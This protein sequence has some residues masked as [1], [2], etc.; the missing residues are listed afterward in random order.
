MVSIQSWLLG[1]LSGF[2]PGDHSVDKSMESAASYFY[3]KLLL[4]LLISR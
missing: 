2:Q 4:V 1:G 3:L